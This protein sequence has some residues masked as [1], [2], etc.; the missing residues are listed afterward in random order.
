MRAGGVANGAP[1]ARSGGPHTGRGCE[2]GG[3]FAATGPALFYSA[4]SAPPSH[5]FTVR[6]QDALANLSPSADSAT[7]LT[8]PVWPLSVRKHR[9]DFKSQ[10]RIVLSSPALMRT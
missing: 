8:P 4:G 5:S 1:T 3:L 10:N 9:P 2:H 7:P 6:S